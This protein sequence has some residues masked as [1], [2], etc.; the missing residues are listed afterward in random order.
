MLRKVDGRKIKIST[1]TPEIKPTTIQ[2]K[3]PRRN[4][5]KSDD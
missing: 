3:Q 4:E 2:T 1:G 5:R